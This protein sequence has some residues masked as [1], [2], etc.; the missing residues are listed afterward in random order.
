MRPKSETVKEVT[1]LPRPMLTIEA[2][3]VF[4]G[5]AELREKTRVRD[6]LA[7]VGVEAAELDV[8]DLARDAEAGCGRR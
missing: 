7:V 8:E 4:E 3:E 1:W 6:G 2:V 5:R